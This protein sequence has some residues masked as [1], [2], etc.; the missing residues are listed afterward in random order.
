MTNDYRN[1]KYC[2]ELN[3]TENKK[4]SIVKLIK[5]THPRAID[6][7]KYVCNN[8]EEYKNEFIKAYNGK[9]SYCGVSIDLIP[10]GSFEID[11]YIYE[12]SPKFSSKKEAGQI[13]NLVLACRDCNHKKGSF[14]ISEEIYDALYPDGEGIK[15]TFYRNEMYYIYISDALKENQSINDFYIQLQLGGE[16]HRLDFLL[17]SMIGLR[18][19]HAYNEN[20][21]VRV[22]KIIDMLRLKRNLM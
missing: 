11:H 6:M 19:R 22:G 9:C 18:N 8:N 20:L 12:K 2:P 14:L 16:I 17:M 3:D 10:K 5:S 7:H 1:T 21:Y 15:N 4:N 13:K